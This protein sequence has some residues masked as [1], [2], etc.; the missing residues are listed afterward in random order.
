MFLRHGLGASSGLAFCF[1]R[2]ESVLQPR[3]AESGRRPWEISMKSSQPHY[4]VFKA[5]VL[6]SNANVYEELAT[7]PAGCH[8]L[9]VSVDALSRKVQSR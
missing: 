3:V 6:C 1:S 7:P 9:S 4:Q 8:H 5:I 2:R